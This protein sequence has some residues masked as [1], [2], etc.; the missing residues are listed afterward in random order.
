MQEV[1]QRVHDNGYVYKGLYEGWY[2]PRCAD[3]KS[4]NEQGPDHTCL[5]HNIPLT[6]E[7]EENYFFALSKFQ[8][9]LEELLAGDFVQP[10]A[11]ANEARAFVAQG[12]EDV[13][14][15]R[16]K[17]TWGVRV[18]WDESHVF[19]VWFDALLNYY[20]ALSMRGAATTWRTASGAR[21]RS[22]SSAR[23][24]SSS[25]RSTGRRC[26]WRRGSRSRAASSS[27]ASCSATTGA[28]CRSPT[29]TCSTRSRSSTASAPTPCA[30]TSCA[31]SASARTAACSMAGVESRYTTELANDLGN[32]AS[33]TI[34]MVERYRD[35][36]VP[37]RRA[38]HDAGLRGARATRS[39]S[40]MDAWR[41]TRRARARLAAR[42]PAE[43][44]TSRSRPR[45]S[46]RRTPTGP[47]T[48]TA[49]SRRSSTACAASR[50]C[51]SRSSPTRWAKLT[52]R[53]RG[54]PR[55]VARAAVPEAR[56]GRAR[57][58]QPHPSGQLRARR[59]RPRPRPPSRRASSGCSPSAPTRRPCRAALQAA[60][61][62]PQ[63]Y[64]AIGRHPNSAT[65]FDDADLADLKA[66]AQHDRCRAIGETGL[67]FY[68]DRTPPPDQQRAFEAQIELARETG[69]PL[70]IHTRAADDPTIATL[71]D[72]ADGRHA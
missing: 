57:D 50:T 33:R 69:K 35:G 72:Q 22:T 12:L 36:E 14:L 28:R 37:R 41:I 43:R 49:R 51:S 6:R 11:R 71:S 62:F 18:P 67:D 38:G 20:T 55:R 16:G 17:L 47:P 1:L 42:P 68:R 31:T 3:F 7:E 70:V 63:V 46:S 21:R 53:R 61:R 19:Y 8:Q 52:R 56:S 24:S 45:G 25:T 30:S 54:R 39:P 34:K 26:S 48:S 59:R 10:K 58:R 23:T 29:A 66:L 32:L 2:C 44:A 65:G 40:A 27:T 13:S 15:T 5:I 64:A 4:E 60:E 9:Q